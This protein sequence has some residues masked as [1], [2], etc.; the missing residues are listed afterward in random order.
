MATIVIVAV[1]TQSTVMSRCALSLFYAGRTAECEVDMVMQH[2]C[3]IVGSRIALVKKAK[4]LGGTHI[5]FI[6]DD[7]SFVSANGKSVIDQLLSNEKEIVGAPYNWRKFPLQSTA[8]PATSEMTQEGIT[9]D[10]KTLPEELFEC[11]TVGTGILLIDLAV[12]DTLPEPWF[13]FIRNAD[14]S[15]QVGEDSHFCI[16]ARNNGFKVWADHVVKVQHVSEYLY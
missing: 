11:F 9:I 1:P 4:E 2:G 15:L 14:G 7:M 3:D 12:F 6:D 16:L 13:D 5:L 10:P 8:V